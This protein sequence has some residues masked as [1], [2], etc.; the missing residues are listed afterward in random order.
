MIYRLLIHIKLIKKLTKT[1]FV[2]NIVDSL[3]YKLRFC[4]PASLW[5]R[6]LRLIASMGYGLS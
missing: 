6:V 2:Q 3:K 4:E 1:G 5:I